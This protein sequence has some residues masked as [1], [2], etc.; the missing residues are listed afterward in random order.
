MTPQSAVVVL[1]DPLAVRAREPPLQSSDESEF[2][3]RV[4]NDMHTIY[5]HGY[6]LLLLYYIPSRC[7]GRKF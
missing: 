5:G 2:S 7:D 6:V 1:R 4:K 3:V